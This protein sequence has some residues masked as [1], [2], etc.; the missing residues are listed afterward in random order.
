MI[1][2]EPERLERSGSPCLTRLS[3]YG[4]AMSETDDSIPESERPTLKF[5]VGEDLLPGELPA[6]IEEDVATNPGPLEFETLETNTGPAP[7]EELE[8][9]VIEAST[10]PGPDFLEKVA[11][12]N[13]GPPQLELEE[14]P[15][16]RP[17]SEPLRINP[18]PP[19]VEF[20]TSPA[21]PPPSPKTNPGPPTK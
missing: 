17:S 1:G 4:E 16:P 8:N 2:S 19:Q 15:L 3:R 20:D 7:E 10:N 12:T 14:I 5:P 21:P 9:L 11:S 6:E 13:P 18:G